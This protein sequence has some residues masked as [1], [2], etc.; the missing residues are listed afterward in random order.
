M[1]RLD[2]LK[3]QIR[4]AL[5]DLDLVIGWERGFDP[6]HATP[7]HI[8]EEA[9]IDRL[10]FD[11][12]CVHNLASFLTGLAG[13][14][15]G[16]VVKGCDS[17]TVVQLIQEKL[18]DR[19]SVVI[20]G[21]PCTGVLDKA[22]L[23]AAV[24]LTRVSALDVDG[25]TVRITSGD[26]T[27]EKDLKDLQATKC[28]SCKY[29]NPLE[30]DHLAGKP[31][32]PHGDEAVQYDRIKAFEDTPVEERFDFWVGEMDRCIRCYACR[33]ACPLC[34]CR[35]HCIGDSRDPHWLSQETDI[36][37]KWMF[38]LIHAMHLAG[39]CTEC[40]ECERACPMDIPVL[41]FK[42]K[43]SSIVK[44]LFNYESG[45]DPTAV[46]P[47]FTFQVDEETINERGW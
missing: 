40:G 22:K 28:D 2:T 5:P 41:M 3:E 11:A 43:L 31:V 27:V 29:P 23:K 12:T 42:K 37:N 34:V 17:R 10:I 38:Q 26:E 39:R 24:D 44:D 25:D 21:L 35:D 30:F 8:K 14:K 18:I 4:K 36:R 47:L 46:P 7:F 9:D 13:K 32:E 20:F 45:V 16:V 6:F 33:N 15:V 1:S 19:E